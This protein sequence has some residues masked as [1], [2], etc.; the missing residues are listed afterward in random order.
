L[1]K[2]KHPISHGVIDHWDDME[3]LWKHAFSL[4]KIA[5]NECPV[6]LTEANMNPTKH[7]KKNVVDIFLKIPSSCR[8]RS[9][10]RCFIAVID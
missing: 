1:Y 9:S 10:S 6:L 5:P 8:F 2:L 4:L 3:L 7:K